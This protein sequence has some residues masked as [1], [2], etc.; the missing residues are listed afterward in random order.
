[1]T[2]TR[3]RPS[4]VLATGF[5]AGYVPRAPGTAGSAVGVLLFLILSHLSPA[6]YLAATAA[7]T[8]AAIWIAA[9]SEKAFGTKDPPQIVIDEIAGQL[10]ALALLPPDWRYVLAGFALFRFFDIVKPWPANKINRD[11]PGGAG[12]VLDDVVAGVYA[13]AVAQCARIFFEFG[14]TL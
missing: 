7:V 13:N 5:G 14:G 2:R 10:I 8:L 1:M 11:M 3:L 12:I 6:A 9:A 4:T